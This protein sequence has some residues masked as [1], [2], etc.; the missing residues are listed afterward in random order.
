MASGQICQRLAIGRGRKVRVER[1]PPVAC[2]KVLYECILSSSGC[3]GG[4]ESW[5]RFFGGF[6]ISG[7]RL[8]ERREDTLR[9][10]RRRY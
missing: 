5:L 7:G 1:R 8:E 4:W 6:F 3:R 2:G 9:F 10:E